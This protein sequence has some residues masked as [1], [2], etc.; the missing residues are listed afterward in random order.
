[1]G[2]QKKT[3]SE[4][5]KAAIYLHVY[6]GV[7]NWKLL[8]KIASPGNYDAPETSSF[9]TLV[10]SWK[11]S[12]KIK[13]LLAA[14]QKDRDALE[15]QLR[16]EGI[17]IGKTE[18]LSAAENE[19]NEGNNGRIVDYSKPENQRRKLNE[20]INTAADPNDAL[21]ALK[22]II[23]GQKD[24]RQAAKEGRAVRAYLPLLCYQ[25]PLYE[26]KRNIIANNVTEKGL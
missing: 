14:I 15:N 16:A 23:S 2:L 12:T 10:S 3:L 6:G 25:C 21:D 7:D 17:T 9:N 13:A 18:L 5:E 11:N 24:D 20:L 4:R 22:V 1:M 8:Y 26:E 19:G